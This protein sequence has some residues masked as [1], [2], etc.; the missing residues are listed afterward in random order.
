MLN[1]TR[2]VSGALLLSV[3]GWALLSVEET[4]LL[5]TPP[6][7]VGSGYSATRSRPEDNPLAVPVEDLKWVADNASTLELGQQRGSTWEKLF[8]S[9]KEYTTCLDDSRSPRK[10]RRRLLFVGDSIL[11]FTFHAMMSQYEGWG[12]SEPRVVHESANQ[13]LTKN[14]PENA[15]PPQERSI[16][17]QKEWPGWG[18][19]FQAVQSRYGDKMCC[20]CK[21]DPYPAGKASKSGRKA[22]TGA[23]ARAKYFTQQ[24]ENMFFTSEKLEASFF[25]M[26]GDYGS[27]GH[28]LPGSCEMQ[29]Q[30]TWRGRIPELVSYLAQHKQT[31][32]AIFIS[33]GLWE[34]TY[35]LDHAYVK[36][37]L[38]GVEGLA[39][40]PEAKLFWMR[41][42]TRCD[43][44]ASDREKSIRS[45]LAENTTRAWTHVDAGALTQSLWDTAG[46]G[47]HSQPPSDERDRK[48]SKI[49][50]DSFHFQPWVSRQLGNYLAYLSC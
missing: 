35:L 18:A 27:Y 38:L 25:F 37:L 1:R 42:T 30:S 23:K 20:D 34:P 40:S 31:Y 12:D 50:V 14:S 41:P 32:D 15:A 19:L 28:V 47:P 5:N 49:Y 45:L 3:C 8:R 39:A 44:A 2:L 36:S 29:P 9:R 24:R 7:V 33:P 21:R 10:R 17:T 16:L 4:P 11:R 43:G 6:S 26:H 22:N 48:Y 13:L 46:L